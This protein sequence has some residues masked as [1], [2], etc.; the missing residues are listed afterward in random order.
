M[1]EAAPKAKLHPSRRVHAPC[2]YIVEGSGA[3][4]K[5]WGKEPQMFVVALGVNLGFRV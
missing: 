5:Y 2:V 4:A 1:D 3:S